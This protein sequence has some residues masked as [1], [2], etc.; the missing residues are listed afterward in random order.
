M[1]GPTGFTAW[2]QSSHPR[3]LCGRHDDADVQT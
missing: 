3:A 2:Y 1:L